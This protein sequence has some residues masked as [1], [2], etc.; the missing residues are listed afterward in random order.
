[1]VLRLVWGCSDLRQRWFGMRLAELF[2][3]LE[4]LKHHDQALLALHR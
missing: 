2:V 1:M 4:E 3:I